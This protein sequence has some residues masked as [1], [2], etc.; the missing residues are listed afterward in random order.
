MFAPVK[1]AG[2]RFI[3]RA[4]KDKPF[5]RGL[6]ATD[7]AGRARALAESAAA[8]RAAR[9]AEA[10]ADYES[11]SAFHSRGITEWSR[12]ACEL[13]NYLAEQQK[14][15]PGRRGS[16]HDPVLKAKQLGVEIARE[17][18]HAAKEDCDE[19][20]RVLQTL[21]AEQEAGGAAAAGVL[22]SGGA[23]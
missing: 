14:K 2:G 1:G 12:A 9:L 16:T 10:E 21:E 20:L 19:A 11:C 7:P 17:W 3:A 18:M 5:A 8:E 22:A 4:D 23:E 13:L 15:N 6:K